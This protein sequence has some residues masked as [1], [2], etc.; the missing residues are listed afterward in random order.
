MRTLALMF[1][2][3]AFVTACAPA[4]TPEPPT[5][6]PPTSIPPTAIP[7]TDPPAPTAPAAPVEALVASM[8]ELAGLWWFTGCP[9]K[10]Q[11]NPDGSYT[12]LARANEPPEAIGN[13]TLDAGKVTWVTSDPLCKDLPAATYE[14]YVTRQEGKLVSLRLQLVGT[15]ACAMRVDAF[16]GPAKFL[17]P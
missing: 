10:A 11:F 9:C 4:A 5:A 6:I 8:D 3:A 1:L 7:P 2:V 15:D 12:I 16:K 13:F 17:N 14:A